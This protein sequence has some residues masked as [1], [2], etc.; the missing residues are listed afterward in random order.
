MLS[1]SI[2]IST[3]AT[4][5]H[6]LPSGS[7]YCQIDDSNRPSF[8][9]NHGKESASPVF[10]A[11]FTSGN[12]AYKINLSKK[13]TPIHG[14]LLYVVGSDKNKH[15][16]QF[17]QKTGF[18]FVTDCAGGSG[19]TLTHENSGAKQ[20]TEFIWTPGPNDSG[21]FTLHAVVTGDKMPWQ[22]LTVNADRGNGGSQTGAAP[23]D[24]SVP[25]DLYGEL[26]IFGNIKAQETESAE[27]ISTTTHNTL[28]PTIASKTA[29][30]TQLPAASDDPYYSQTAAGNIFLSGVKSK[31]RVFLY[32]FYALVLA[33]ILI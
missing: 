11:Q 33:G 3:I 8:E 25:K 10:E 12:G 32:S 28:K 15:L 22:I 2:I 20:D 19:S 17:T 31:E 21:P 1:K 14:V 26:P 23:T 5:T 6:A 29:K 4:L 24:E 30:A 13:E 9:S 27:P 16:G 18:K 7:P